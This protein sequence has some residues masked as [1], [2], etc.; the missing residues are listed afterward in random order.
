M[1]KKV[2]DL[3]YI[4]FMCVGSV[5]IGTSPIFVRLS[6]LG[7]MATGFYR[8]LLALP[9]LGLWMKWER[10][11]N[12][13][14]NKLQG[15]D[16]VIL[17]FAG[18]LF[19]L[20]LG[21]WNWSVD[22][23]TIV[24]ST[25][26]NNTAAFFVP[27]I[28]WV[29]FQKTPS[30]RFILATSVGF[31]GCILLIGQSISLSYEN[32]LGDVIALSSG[33]MVALYLISLKYIRERISTGFLMFWTGFFSF[34]FLSLFVYLSGESLGPFTFQDAIS[35]AGQAVL[36]HTIGQSLLAISLGK[37]SSSYAALILFLAPV[38]AAVLGWLIY[39]EALGIM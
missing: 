20:D 30:F 25:L 21:L 7:P 14:H 2:F 13:V 11:S 26:F 4:I 15:N 35:I 18:A 3:K 17:V 6:D 1:F 38:N 24:N 8:M 31:I 19:A 32:L 12:L 28:M 5:L 34:I 29:F 22:H 37:I 33:L 10:K 36:V 23:T 39:S 9:L 27:L 16:F